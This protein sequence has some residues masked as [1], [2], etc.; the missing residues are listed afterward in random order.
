MGMRNFIERKLGRPFDFYRQSAPRIRP[1]NPD[2]WPRF[3]LVSD[4][5][6]VCSLGPM[7][8]GFCSLAAGDER[9]SCNR[10]FVKEIHAASNKMNAILYHP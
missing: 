3:E 7:F 10:A 1:V 5:Q 6:C 4:E 2:R 9:I 8:A